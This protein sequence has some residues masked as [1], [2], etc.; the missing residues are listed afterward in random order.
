MWSTESKAFCASK[1]RMKV[2]CFLLS[3]VFISS[4]M[5][6]ALSVTC[7]PGTYPHCVFVR[8]LSRCL[9][10]LSAN[11]FVQILI[12]QFER[13][14]GLRFSIFVLSLSFFSRRVITEYLWLLLSLPV[15][16][17]CSQTLSISGPRV[18]QWSRYTL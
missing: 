18:S 10:V 1:V 8:I 12:S 17:A 15:F 16:C 13:D 11:A 14:I 6:L 5:Y 3:A 2:F 7:L 4:C 9:F